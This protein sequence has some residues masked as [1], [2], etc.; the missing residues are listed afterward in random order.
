[1]PDASTIDSAVKSE[2]KPPVA[3]VGVM[4]WVRANLFNNWYNSL[5]TIV[6]MFILWQTVIPTVRWALTRDFPTR[7]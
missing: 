2:I 1:M 6:V 3:S 4:G 7:C 5:L